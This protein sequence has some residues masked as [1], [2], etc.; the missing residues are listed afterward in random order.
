[1]FALL[2]PVSFSKIDG[3]TVTK[4][5]FAGDEAAGASWTDKIMA[6]KASG[7]GAAKL[8]V[9]GEGADDDEWVRGMRGR[10]RLF[11]PLLT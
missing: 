6:N 3:G 4:C 5:N 2:P 7:E 8:G 1:M 10:K 11:F 9:Q